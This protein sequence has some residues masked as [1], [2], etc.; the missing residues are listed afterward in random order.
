[1]G[2]VDLLGGGLDSLVG[3]SHHLKLVETALQQNGLVGAYQSQ[4]YGA[5]S[6]PFFFF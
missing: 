1:M 5:F 6:L 2:A 3:P 4:L